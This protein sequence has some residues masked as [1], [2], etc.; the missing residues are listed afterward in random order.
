MTWLRCIDHLGG[1]EPYRLNP[2]NV[3]TFKRRDGWWRAFD[4]HGDA[5]DVASE[6]DPLVEAVMCGR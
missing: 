6:D 2:A 1:G 4:V 5:H 3:V